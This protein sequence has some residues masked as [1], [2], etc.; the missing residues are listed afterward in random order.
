WSSDV[1]SSDLESIV[2]N[3]WKTV[4][5]IPVPKIPQASKCADFR[6]ISITPALSRVM[7]KLLTRHIIYPTLQSPVITQFLSNQYAFRPTGSTT[8]ALI[9]ILNDLSS[10]SQNYPYVHIIALDFSKAFDTVRHSTMMEKI[11]ALPLPDA[12]Y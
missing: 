8:A 4:S 9:S 1:C 2:P 3:Q 10:L 6:P 7:E 11:S 12:L 5:T